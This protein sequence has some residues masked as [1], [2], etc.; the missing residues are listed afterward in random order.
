MYLQKMYEKCIVKYLYIQM[1]DPLGRFYLEGSYV[2]TVINPY[3]PHVVM[4]S[5]GTEN[6]I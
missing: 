5:R 4:Q 3:A 2:R 6:D 1:T